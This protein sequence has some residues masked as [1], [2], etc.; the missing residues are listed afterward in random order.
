ME[1]Q[2]SVLGTMADCY[3]DDVTE[4]S[5]S[6]HSCNGNI[7]MTSLV[8]GRAI[9]NCIAQSVGHLTR[10]SGVLGSIPDLAT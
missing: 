4:T 3:L 5:K 6:F 10:K 1:F 2:T 7:F 9:S 8:P